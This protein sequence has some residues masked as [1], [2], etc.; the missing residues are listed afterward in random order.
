MKDPHNWRCVVGPF[1]A[2]TF[3]L[4]YSALGLIEHYNRSYELS[5]MQPKS[6]QLTR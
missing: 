5:L 6:N 3:C 1:H 2:F 4:K